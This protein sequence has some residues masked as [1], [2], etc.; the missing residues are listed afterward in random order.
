MLPNK[1]VGLVAGLLSVALALPAF[2]EANYPSQPL[3]AYIGFR[4]GGGTDTIGRVVTRVMSEKLEQQINVIN[5]PGAGGGIAASTIQRA[6]PDGYSFLLSSTTS[7]TNAPLLNK[8]LKY[9]VSDF[10]YA[11]IIAAYQ[12]GIAAP[13][14]KPFNTLPEFIEHTRKNPGTKYV[15]LT[16]LSRLIM[17]Y[18]VDKE[19]I[20]VNFVPAK[21]GSA[22][23]NL[24]A[25]N[26]VDAGYTG[27]FHQRHP[28]KMKLLVAATTKRHPAN[29]KSATLMELGIPIAANAQI[30][31]VFPKGTPDAIVTKM[32]AAIKAAVGHPDVKKISAKFKYPLDYHT[33]AA[34]TK[35]MQD[36]H[37]FYKKIIDN[38]K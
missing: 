37:A 11:G 19:K 38:A 21:G 34:A 30:A 2:A 18:I 17:Q 26:Q 3:T 20:K 9:G 28:D 8:S 13:V 24:F 35:E 25:S 31:V 29:P 27:G 4:A 16:P 6:K 22:V 10:K 12:A 32:E 1:R 33:A 15:F 5:K 14:D 7:I 36:Q 23:L